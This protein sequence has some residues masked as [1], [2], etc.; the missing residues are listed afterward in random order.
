MALM[1]RMKFTSEKLLHLF[2][3]IANLAA[4][5]DQRLEIGVYGGSCLML[6][7]NFRQATQ[8]VDYVAYA[9]KQY[10]AHLGA[11]VGRE[12]GMDEGWFNDGVIPYLSPNVE[13]FKTAHHLFAVLPA[14]DNPALSVYIPTADYLLAMKLM[15]SRLDEA[16][17]QKDK[18]DILGLMNVLKLANKEQAVEI[19]CKYYPDARINAKMLLSMNH[20]WNEYVKSQED[21]T[22]EKAVYFGRSGPT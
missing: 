5:D 14:N 13:E 10:I 8:D 20:L 9:N 22:Y 6:A 18:A 11:W 7:G 21:M 12:N 15:A 1:P 3:R 17:Q 19:A 2:N 16:E 4:G